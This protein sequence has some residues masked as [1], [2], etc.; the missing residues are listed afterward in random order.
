MPT[1]VLVA[2]AEPA[3]QFL[4]VP[5]ASSRQ[6]FVLLRNGRANLPVFD[7]CSV[8]LGIQTL[9]LLLLFLQQDQAA[10][11]GFNATSVF[12]LLSV[13]FGTFA[14]LHRALPSLL[15]L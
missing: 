1:T 5:R 10:A 13:G 4:T 7:V 14:F 12:D 2:G 9:A 15:G 3:I 8:S 11:L 6:A